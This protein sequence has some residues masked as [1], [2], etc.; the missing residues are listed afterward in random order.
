M[1]Q[2]RTTG[3]VLLGVLLSGALT[4]GAFGIAPAANATCASFFGIN[5][6][7]GCGSSPTSI[8]IAIGTGAQAYAEGVLGAAFSI[9]TDSLTSVPGG[10][11]NFFNLASAFGINAV[12]EAGGALSVALAAGQ[13]MSALASIGLPSYLPVA[14]VAIN[15][16]ISSTNNLSVAEGVGNLAVNLFGSGAGQDVRAIGLGNVAIDLG[17]RVTRFARGSVPA[18]VPTRALRSMS[19]APATWCRRVRVPLQSR[20]RSTNS[21][22]P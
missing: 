18:I 10:G 7:G 21:G 8:A 2:A 5:N 9:G 13:N 17:G 6:G 14:N 11:G 19:G 1:H 3:G 4:A 16:G 12:A 15:L 20:A 22:Q